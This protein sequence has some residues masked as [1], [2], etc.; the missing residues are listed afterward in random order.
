MSE[1]NWTKEK[2]WLPESKCGGV[3]IGQ[4]AS[5]SRPNKVFCD[6]RAN[7]DGITSGDIHEIENIIVASPA[8]YLALEDLLMHTPMK[9]DASAL[10][11]YGK[12]QNTLK[13]ARGE[14]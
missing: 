8:L 14:V 7:V 11:R 13:K 2:W 9:G 10:L 5:D 3:C 1:T 4:S 6:V 12:A